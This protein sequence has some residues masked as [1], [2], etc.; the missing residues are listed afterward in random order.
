MT[1]PEFLVQSPG[2]RPGWQRLF[3][4]FIASQA[5]SLFGSSLVQYAILWYITLE[6]NFRPHDC[7]VHHLW[8]PANLLPVTLCRILGR[9]VRP[10]KADHVFRPRIALATL[11]LFTVFRLGYQSIWMLFL[12]S[13]IRSVG[14]AIQSP[15]V[16][17][18]LP[19]IVPEG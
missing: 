1:D 3:A 5:V 2:D 9:Q 4:V 16:S 15:A 13:A 14:T 6:T 10:Q 12:I 18:F 11:D 7:A 19:Q 8:L 17:A